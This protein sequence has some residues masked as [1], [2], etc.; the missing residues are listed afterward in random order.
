MKNNYKLN[1]DIVHEIINKSLYPKYKCDFAYVANQTSDVEE[2]NELMEHLQNLKYYLHT[3]DCN[4]A[5][6]VYNGYEIEVYKFSLI[7]DSMSLYLKE[8]YYQMSTKQFY[9]YVALYNE[10]VK[11][12]SG[13]VQVEDNLPETPEKL[14][15]DIKLQKKILLNNIKFLRFTTIFCAVVLFILM[16][17]TSYDWSIG[18]ELFNII[19][20]F[21]FM[22][23]Y[24][25]LYV[26]A[27]LK[28]FK[29]K[30]KLNEIT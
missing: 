12:K 10:L 9:E 26:M 4:S 3:T 5:L 11:T 30:D 27:H 25:F 14:E 2:I 17:I 20:D 21:T 23:A 15:L 16:T 19:I 28:Y 22:G 1:T 8:K 24:L 13:N 18:R 29:L 6:F 7:K